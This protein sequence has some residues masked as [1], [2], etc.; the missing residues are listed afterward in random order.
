MDYAFLRQ[1]GIRHLERLAGRLWTDYNAHD[2]GITILEQLC[3]ALTDL[4]YR[5]DYPLPDLLYSQG[6]EAQAGFVGPTDSLTTRPV[7]P[8]DW[9][10]LL[11]DVP[12]IRNAW[13]EVDQRPADQPDFYYRP[14]TG[15]LK[16]EDDPLMAD[17]VFLKG[18]YRV[19][20]EFESGA[21]RSAAEK[22]ALARLQA[23][24]NLGEDF[25]RITPLQDQEVQVLA[26]VEIGPVD[27]P[28]QVLL[29]I[30]RQLSD[31]ISPSVRFYTLSQMLDRDNRVNEI[32]DG[33]QLAHGFIDPA[34]LAQAQRR[35]TLHTSDL[36]QA[37][38]DVPGVKAVRFIT[39]SVNGDF[40]QQTATTE[41]S[42]GTTTQIW[43]LNLES[44]Q[45]PKF[46]INK[47]AII[48]ER[49]GLP[50][51]VNRASVRAEYTQM[52][53]QVLNRPPLPTTER[54]FQPPRGQNREVGRYHS[55]QHQ[56]PATYGIGDLGLSTSAPPER[57]AQAKQLQAYLLFFDQ[58]LANY[59]AQLS[60]VKD[61]FA[62]AGVTDQTYFVQP[63]ADDTLG[64]DGLRKE[65]HAKRLAEIS[66]E[67]TTTL[68]AAQRRNRFLNHLLARF[69]EQFTDYALLQAEQAQL[70][71]DKEAFL[72]NYP[73]LSQARGT[74]YNYLQP[75]GEENWAGLEKR[76]RYKLGLK[77][78]EENF[79]VVEH[80][81][82]RPMAGD[83]PVKGNR[84][85]TI[86]ILTA[87]KY[88]D[89]YSLRLSFIFPDLTEDSRYA[90]PSFRQ[91]VHHTVRE[92][93]PAHLSVDIQWLEPDQLQV[94]KAAYQEW[95]DKRR[96]YWLDVNAGQETIDDHIR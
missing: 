84:K 17:P 43:S 45:A 86:P 31:H 93:T 32:F 52:L 13:V 49:N 9:R 50:V 8:S 58:L 3:Y 24:R 53:Q 63:I 14:Q 11:I 34:E 15:V 33:P 85:R 37:I 92:E 80:I 36:I 38:M 6:G 40:S 69:A 30:Y 60:N 21:N 89:P 66:G 10:K 82:L 77:L 4:A 87:A 94:F 72:Q 16:F 1:E 23:N 19:L 5:I 26:H 47:S 12:G 56:F 44:T 48:L 20:L 68:G 96:A 81:L 62:F 79:M 90:E 42:T 83:G 65:G 73:V 55:V 75:A 2:P 35:S 74:A 39:M 54:D 41:T 64:L 29:H 67:A 61:L 76:I 51:Q 95:L 7:T 28:E 70:I 57:Q 25:A 18:L 59:F 46:D 91:F 27:N 71:D 22:E 88:Q 78:P